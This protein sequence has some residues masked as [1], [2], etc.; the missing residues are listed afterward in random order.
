MDRHSP[1]GLIATVLV[2]SRLVV[3]V[4]SLAAMSFE[5]TLDKSA[6]WMPSARWTSR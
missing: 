5:S 4:M 3:A 1:S 2:R 6:L